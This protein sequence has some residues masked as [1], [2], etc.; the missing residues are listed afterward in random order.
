MKAANKKTI[1]ENHS[2]ILPSRLS[3]RN[4]NHKSRYGNHDVSIMPSWLSERTNL[5][6]D[7]Q[8]D[9]YSITS[10]IGI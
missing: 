7:F 2:T 6:W 4:E 10:S 1:D 9:I 3:D 5:S 8:N